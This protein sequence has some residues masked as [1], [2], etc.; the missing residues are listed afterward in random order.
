MAIGILGGLF[1][2]TLLNLFVLPALYL[3]IGRGARRVETS[4]RIRATLNRG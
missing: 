2:S 3:R 4:W 1:T